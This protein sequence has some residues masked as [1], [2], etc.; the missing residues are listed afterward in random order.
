MGVLRKGSVVGRGDLLFV[1][2]DRELEQ[3]MPGL[4]EFL[5]LARWDDGSPRVP[6]TVLLMAQDGVYKAWLNDRDCDRSA[7]LSAPGI[8]ELLLSVN[9]HLVA[10]TVPWRGADPRKRR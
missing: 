7:F 6:G 9:D 1:A 2:E 8:A 10:D 3:R 5:S 4:F